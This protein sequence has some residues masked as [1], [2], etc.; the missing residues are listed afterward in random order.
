MLTEAI[1]RTH[2]RL[3]PLPPN[4]GVWDLTPPH[5]PD[6]PSLS[7][8]IAFLLFSINTVILIAL[9]IHTAEQ[10]II[11]TMFDP[12]K[13]ISWFYYVSISFF[14]VY[15]MFSLFYMAK[16][17]WSLRQLRHNREHGVESSSSDLQ[18]D[19]ESQLQ[20]LEQMIERQRE[21]GKAK[22]LR[23]R[24]L[25]AAFDFEVYSEDT[26][27]GTVPLIQECWEDAEGENDDSKRG[28]VKRTT[29]VLE[30]EKNKDNNVN[31]NKSPTTTKSKKCLKKCCSTGSSSTSSTDESLIN[32]SARTTNTVETAIIPDG[33]ESTTALSRR[34]DK[35]L[36]LEP[37][38][39]ICLEPYEYGQVICSA[40]TK[41][42]G[43]I[44]H[45][46]CIQQWVQ[47]NE[48]CP[49]C[50][51]TLIHEQDSDH[52]AETCTHAV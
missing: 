51:V 6:S 20:D 3:V 23:L 31:N 36:G 44:F 49:L 9:L 38:C 39:V 5:A 32:G 2:V 47:Q 30:T 1:S 35:E 28:T 48:E 42:C 12:S 15:V 11:S 26:T 37:E 52:H 18:V 45:A 25:M 14:F 34:L 33:D 17:T 27:I 16:R 10:H 43:H 19:P 7:Y 22:A 21:D 13:P 46:D 8:C 4:W 50:R 41:A 24:K 40:K 29:L